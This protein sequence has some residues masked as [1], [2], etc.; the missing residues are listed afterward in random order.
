[1]T[2][3]VSASPYGAGVPRPDADFPADPYPGAVP[4]TSFVHVDEHSHELT[5]DAR[6]G[7]TVAGVPLDTWL[8]SRGVPPAARRVPVLT[9]G[10]NRCPGKITWLRRTLGLGREPVVVLRARTEGVAA[11]WAAGLRKRDGQRPAVLAAAPGVAEEHGVWLATPEQIAVLDRCEGRDVRFRLARLRTGT[12]R[13]ED[14]L[15]VEAPWCYVGHAEIRRPLLV[16]DAAVRCADLP[17]AAALAL[18]GTA[19]T[20][21]GLD[22]VTVVGAPHPD[23]WP[24]ALFVYGLLQ[25]GSPSWPLVAPHAAGESRRVTVDGTVHDTGLGYPALLPGTGR[26]VPGWIVPLRDPVAAL[27]DLDA[28]EGAAYRR[29]RLAT[30]AGRPAWTYAWN[31]PVEGMPELPEG[32]PAA[33]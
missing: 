33:S 15:L 30:S 23:E 19:A 25:P 1:V 6:A 13:T 29:V 26:R 14:G 18:D 17:Q 28:Y 5:V 9:Y 22:A 16:D 7:W 32:W 21:D 8:R 11:V 2:G 10:S 4:P 24:A 27:P 3:Q 12:V 20:G 31:G